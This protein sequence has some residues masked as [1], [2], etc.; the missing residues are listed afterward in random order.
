MTTLQIGDTPPQSTQVANAAGNT[1]SP[2]LMSAESAATRAWNDFNAKRHEQEGSATSDDASNET[3]YAANGAVAGGEP[4]YV[5]P[6]SA[7]AASAS[8]A[9]QALYAA[10][11]VVNTG[12]SGASDT[13][14]ELADLASTTAEGMY[15]QTLPVS[16]VTRSQASDAGGV[17]VAEDTVEETVFGFGRKVV[18]G[19]IRGGGGDWLA[20]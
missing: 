2:A 18:F 16:A 20:R 19:G 6:G 12:G 8:R 1:T 15:L 4:A 14:I 5:A 11:G 10:N 13:Y 17:K 7:A 9:N 3:L